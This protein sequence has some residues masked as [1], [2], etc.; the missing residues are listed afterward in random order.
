MRLHP[1][2]IV[3]VSILTVSCLSGCQAKKEYAV[4]LT[5]GWEIAIADSSS[6]LIVTKDL[7]FKPLLQIS[8]LTAADS[9]G[10]F[11]VLR[12]RFDLRDSMPSLNLGLMLGRIVKADITYLNGS[13]LGSTGN[14]PPNK[15]NPWNINRNYPIPN[16]LIKRK[17]NELLVKIYFEPGRG[18][19]F[20]APIIANRK[21]LENLSRLRTFYYVDTYKI[22]AVIS[23]LASIIFL[24]IFF[25]RGIDKKFLYYTIA[26][27]L[28]A[29][30]SLYHF[31]WSLPFLSDISFFDSV[32]FQKILWIALFLFSFF[33]ALFLYE[34]LNRHKYVIHLKIVK[35]LMF[36]TTLGII[37]AWS[38]QSLESIRKLAFL[39]S[40][41]LVVLTAYWTVTAIKDKVQY[42]KSVFVVYTIFTGL[43]IT[44]VLI[45]IFNLYLPYFAP[46]AVPLYLTGLGLI[47]INQYVDANYEIEQL[48]VTLDQKN[49]EIEAKNIDLTKLDKLKD[50]FLANTSH[51]L[52]TPLNGIIGIAESLID[53]ATGQLKQSTIYNLD[54][55]VHSGKR[56]TS[57]IGDILD[58]SQIKNDKFTLYKGA[59][60]LNKITDQVILLTKPLWSVKPLQLVNEISSDLPPAFADDRRVEQIMFNLIGN[61]IKFTENGEIA[62]RA[63]LAG[64]WIEVAVSD[65]GI[66]IPKDKFKDI[67][68]SF[69]QV[70][71]SSDD[72][73]YQGTGLGLSITKKLIELHGGTIMVSSEIGVGSTF[74]FTLPKGIE[75]LS[76]STSEEREITRVKESD[77]TEEEIIETEMLQEQIYTVL[78]IDD[79]PINLQV[80]SNHLKTNN[81]KVKTAL[82]GEEA[83][84]LIHNEGEPNLIIL[85]VM[86]PKMSGFEVCR[87]IRDEYPLS[88]MPVILLTA[89]DRIS[90]LTE[91][92]NSGANDYL[93]KPFSKRELL[94]RIKTHLSLSL[95]NKAYSRF[96]PNEFLNLL[97]RDSII[98]IKLGDQQQYEMTVLFSDIRDFT[99]LSEKMSPKE[100][101]DFLNGYL[102]QIGPIIRS[103]N[104]FIDKYIGDAIMALFP[105]GPDDAIKAAISIC[106]YLEAYNKNR[107]IDAKPPI[108]IG[109]GIHTGSMI[110]GT[111]G[112]LERMESTVISDAVNLGSRLEGLTKIYGVSILASEY[113]IQKLKHAES[114]HYRIIDRV[115]VKGKEQVVSIA[116]I[117]DGDSQETLELKQKSKLFFEKGVSAYELNDY[118]Q[119][120]YLFEQVCQIYPEDGPTLFYLEKLKKYEA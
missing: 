14:F 84:R 69:E 8:D 33:N 70:E 31:I 2:L 86:M 5:K 98:D 24:P 6:T 34:F 32:L 49:V 83:L 120:T 113:S 114:F 4:Q 35:S 53:G 3:I 119:A 48:T 110:L 21:Y 90:D 115:R 71:T 81:Y 93:V 43:S 37:I 19:I 106:Q 97:N 102:E 41:V 82:S 61:A 36:L 15:T 38:P 64:E 7:L 92:F 58:F 87:K 16:E 77:I 60:Y 75:T 99:S 117:F 111:I 23:F 88:N 42:A 116:E 55:I 22:S 72:R 73:Q 29:I 44:D 104:G 79:E 78:V 11:V 54:M 12:K 74:T 63:K 76:A 65:T 80:L 39:G 66:G 105:S 1:V 40:L 30:W 109:F 20:D 57:L 13:Y 17:G 18:G 62:V 56:L 9:V 100:N 10:G 26:I 103:H 25:K 50:Q 107:I 59:V 89:K 45:D 85:D 51:E 108:N 95:I 47:I 67:F 27:F 94:T 46:I 96:V 91:G 118:K 52:R 68:N 101:F 112:E 28:F